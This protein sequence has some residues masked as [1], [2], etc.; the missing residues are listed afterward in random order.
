MRWRADMQPKESSLSKAELVDWLSLLAVL[1]TA[2]A[3][4]RAALCYTYFVPIQ[5]GGIG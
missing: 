3:R 5:N 4:V 1:G 2:L